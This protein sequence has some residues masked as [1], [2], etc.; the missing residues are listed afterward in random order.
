MP[1]ALL[2][3]ALAPMLVT[4]ARVALGPESEPT[5]VLPA[6]RANALLPIAVAPV[7][8]VPP[9]LAFES[10]PKVRS[11]G[12]VAVPDPAGNKL[13]KPSSWADTTTGKRASAITTAEI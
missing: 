3:L 10:R 12:L 13:V 1:V 5:L 11:S 4:P 6:P 8:K 2:K 7:M 9:P